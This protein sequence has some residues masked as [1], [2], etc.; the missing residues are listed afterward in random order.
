MSA[1]SASEGQAGDEEVARLVAALCERIVEVL[2]VGAFDVEIEHR[3]AIRLRGKGPRQ[4][5]TLWLSPLHIWHSECSADVRMRLFLEQ[6]GL[7]LQSFLSSGR[8]GPWPTASAKPWVSIGED[9]IAMWWGGPTETDVG[10]ALRP[11]E[12]QEIGV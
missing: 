4:G 6:A 3:Y 1:D 5:D 12:R 9:R 2:P 10:V 11:I 7:R 8:N